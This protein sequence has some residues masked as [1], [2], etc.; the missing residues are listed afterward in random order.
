MDTRLQLRLN[1]V[2]RRL[3]SVHLGWTLTTIWLLAAGLGCALI[4]LARAGS[5]SAEEAG[6]YLVGTATVAVFVAMIVHASRRANFSELAQRVENRFP[7]LNQRLI[8]AA[9]L[10]PNA[11]NGSFSYLQRSVISEALRHDLLY[12]WRSVVSGSRVAFAWLSNIPAFVFFALV[13]AA[14]WNSPTRDVVRSSSSS[15]LRAGNEPHVLP[16]DT[17]VERGTSLIV[18]AR[19]DGKLPDEVWLLQDNLLAE[20]Q[21]PQRVPMRQSLKDPVFA[22]Y[23]YDVRDSLNYSIEYDG[24][25]TPVYHVDVFEFPSLVRADAVLEYP[26]YTQLEKKTVV[27]TRRITA[28]VGTKLTWQLYLNKPVVSAELLT[29]GG[30]PLALVTSEQDPLLVTAEIELLESISWELKLTDEDGRENAMDVTLRARVL[31]NKESTIRLTAGGDVQV[32]PLQEFDVAAEIKDDFAVQKAGIGYQ[33]GGGELVELESEIADAATKSMKISEMVNFE[34]LNAEPNQLLSYYVWAEDR[35]EQG[36][37]RRVMSDM[38]F[39]EV[40]PFEEI[41]RQGEQPS[42]QEQQQQQQQQ[43]QQGNEQTE[44][45]LELQKQ[46]VVGSW[47]VLRTAKGNDLPKSAEDDMQVLIDSQEQA[48]GLLQEKA[49]ESNVP[50]AEEIIGRAGQSMTQAI[51]M[52][53]AANASLAKADLSK[54]V[55]REQSA[56]QELLRLQSREH[57]VVRSQRSQ[58]QSQSQRSRARQQQIDQL[59]LDNQENR[60]ENERLAQE[61]QNEEQSDLRQIISRLRE[62]ASR[63]ED[64][65]EQL[66]ELEAALQAAETPEEKEELQQ[67]LERLREQQ[68]QMLQDSDELQERMETQSS[69]EMQAAREQ[70]EQARENLQQ[71]SESLRQGNTSQALAAGTRAEEELKQLQDEVRQQAANQ[72]AET[73]QGMR[74]QA[75]ELEKRQDEIVDDMSR[76]ESEPSAGLRSSEETPDVSEKLTQQQEQLEKLLEEMQQTVEQAEDAEPLLAQKLY[77]SFRRTKQQK[78][79]ERIEQTEQLLR[80]NYGPQAR[81]L[82]G[83][84][85][86]DLSIL[87]E[88]IDAAAESVLGSEVDS[89]RLALSQLESLT[90][91]I[92]NEISQATGRDPRGQTQGQEESPDGQQRQPGEPQGQQPSDQQGEQQPGEQQQQGQQQQGEQQQGEQQQG[93]QQQ[94]QQQQGQ[95][96]G[97][98]QQGQQQQGQQQQGQQQQGQQQQGQQQQ[99]QQQ[100]GQQQQGNNRDSSNRANSN[101]DNS[102][103]SNQAEVAHSLPSGDCGSLA[104]VRTSSPVRLGLGE[105]ISISVVTRSRE[106]LSEIGPIV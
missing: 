100:Q 7:S 8:T 6:W 34:A 82:A 23:L 33:F 57:E 56:Y 51:E 72:F 1:A 3:R 30:E 35:D 41:Y 18:T 2:A 46:I 39:A 79:E 20:G 14:L 68:Q 16:G 98:Q 25:T 60:Y 22:A 70:M 71:S 28:A 95:Q 59:E 38:F 90:S 36:E 77:D 47:N 54:A 97:Q 37:I 87:R 104:K 88:D 91:Q 101:R 93:E 15:S 44:E 94:G 105:L 78:V 83:Q 58:S 45:L 103:V 99:G 55:S 11:A 31:P 80:L 102:P 12:H 52:L 65:N 13:L 86:E 75:A 42:Q 63:Q 61:Q 76:A 21:E 32:S 9:D 50:G 67:Q 26:V 89:L 24:S 40:R 106:K 74:Q 29:E 73:M 66:R 17:E 69:E 5:V 48:V 84:S 10:R 27:D 49:Q 85:I 92:D 64:L 43:Q 19:F 81:E 53:R 62:L 96:Q 4:N